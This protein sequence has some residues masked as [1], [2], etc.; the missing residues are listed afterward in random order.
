MAVDRLNFIFI[1]KIKNLIN[2]ILLKYWNA[3]FVGYDFNWRRWCDQK[4]ISRMKSEIS[5]ELD[6]EDLIV[7]FEENEKANIHEDFH[8]NQYN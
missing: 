1:C 6:N 3:K 5:S 8:I 4:Y 7:K 2:N